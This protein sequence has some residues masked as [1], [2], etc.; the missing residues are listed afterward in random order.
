[1][2][3]R[4]PLPVLATRRHNMKTFQASD[5]AL[6]LGLAR[7]TLHHIRANNPGLVGPVQKIRIR[8]SLRQIPVPGSFP[9][10]PDRP[11]IVQRLSVKTPLGKD[12]A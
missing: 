7:H 1:V 9:S 6:M 11:C 2:C 8:E 3:Q 10:L 5:D 4:K 12:A